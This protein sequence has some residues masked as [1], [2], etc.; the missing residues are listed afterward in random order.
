MTDFSEPKKAT[1]LMV[2]INMD[3]DWIY[4][5]Y[6]NKGQESIAVGVMSVGSCCLFISSFSPIFK[7]QNFST[8]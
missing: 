1:K 5:V 4:L 2:G 7:H 8:H 6:L 3:H